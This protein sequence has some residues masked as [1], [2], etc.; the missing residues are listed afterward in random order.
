MTTIDERINGWL[1]DAHAM[2]EQ[3]DQMITAQLKRIEHYPDLAQRM[4]QHLEETRSQR[5][6]LEACM[7]RRGVARSAMKDVGGKF[8]ATMQSLSGIFAGDEVVKSVLASYTFEHM[9]IASYRILVAACRAVGD[10]AT[11]QVCQEICGEEE[12]MAS[13]LSDAMPGITEKHLAL[14]GADRDE[15]K[16]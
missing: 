11:A 13:W 14:E 7:D 12:A 4:Q 5:E 6:R 8:T 10:E 1:R 3:A 9:E 2:E 15:A 16:R